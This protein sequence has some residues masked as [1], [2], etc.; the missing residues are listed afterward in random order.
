MFVGGYCYVVVV[1]VP[2]SEAFEVL[3]EGLRV[4]L[5]PGLLEYKFILWFSELAENL[6][7]LE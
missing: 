4:L 1:V 6:G 5:E 7:G 3:S 2:L